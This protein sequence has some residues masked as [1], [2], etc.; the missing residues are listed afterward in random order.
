MDRKLVTMKDQGRT[1]LNKIDYNVGINES[2]L[3]SDSTTIVEEAKID[4]I[5]KGTKQS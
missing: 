3:I 5:N 4:I 1:N 2:N